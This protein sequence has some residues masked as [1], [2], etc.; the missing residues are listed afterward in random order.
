MVE[1]GVFNQ[2]IQLGMQE[3]ISQLYEGWEWVHEWDLNDGKRELASLVLYFLQYRSTWG[4]VKDI[5]LS[6]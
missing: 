1:G 6:C 4:I 2:L 3:Y 5:H